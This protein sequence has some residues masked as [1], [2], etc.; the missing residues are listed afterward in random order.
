MIISV[1]NREF[2]KFLYNIIWNVGF[3]VGERRVRDQ[4]Y[5]D[6]Y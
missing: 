6:R 5:G 1:I 4:W 2:Y 3:S